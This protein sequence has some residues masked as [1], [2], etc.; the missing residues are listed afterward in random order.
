MFIPTQKCQKQTEKG[1]WKEEESFEKE[2]FPGV[3]FKKERAE[4]GKGEL[5]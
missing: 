5:F 3:V 1:N 4:D 2:S